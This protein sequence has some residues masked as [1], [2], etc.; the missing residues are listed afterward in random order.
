MIK[1]LKR[2][3]RRKFLNAKLFRAV[4]KG[5]LDNISVLLSAGADPNSKHEGAFLLWHAARHSSSAV[6]ALLDSG[7]DPNQNDEK[8]NSPLLTAIFAENHEAAIKL[9][10]AGAS[11]DQQT[12][13]WAIERNAPEVVEWMIDHGAN[14]NG[15]D[16]ERK[17]PLHIAAESNYARV[18][19]VLI[20]RG[21]D[22][23]LRTISGKIWRTPLDD[24]VSSGS[25]D[26]ITALINGGADPYILNHSGC[27]SL[28][29]AMALC[30]VNSFASLLK[31]G[32]RPEP[33]DVGGVDMKMARD[34]ASTWGI[35]WV[36]EQIVEIDEQRTA[37]DPFSVAGRCPEPSDQSVIGLP[38]NVLSDSDSN[39]RKNATDARVKLRSTLEQQIVTQIDKVRHTSHLMPSGFLDNC[40]SLF[41]SHVDDV[42]VSL[43]LPAASQ[44]LSAIVHRA[45]PDPATGI[46]MLVSLMPWSTSETV[47]KL[48]AQ[49]SEKPLGYVRLMTDNFINN[50]PDARLHSWC[51]VCLCVNEEVCAMHTGLGDYGGSSRASKEFCVFPIELLNAFERNLV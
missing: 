4:Q 50:W 8:R 32:V 41:H 27:N 25:V 14:P 30:K 23:N 49:S 1:T 51:H 5:D 2:Y 17:N 35:S 3:I 21:A 19:D 33:V 37:E 18:I 44:T 45:Y 13:V 6:T 16:G 46:Y 20:K 26:A 29:W 10:R 39:V 15:Q 31:N 43:V 12:F 48:A 38:D 11:F 42:V 28:Q 36:M 47:E 22:P 7:V 40:I 9:L 24:A 34:F